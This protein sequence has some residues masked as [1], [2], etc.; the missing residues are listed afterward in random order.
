[1]LDARTVAE[2]R[3]NKPGMEISLTHRYRQPIEKVFAALSTP[4][5][6]AA[7]MGVEWTG[8][9]APLKPGSSFSYRFKNSDMASLGKVTAYEPPRLI[10]HTWFENIP[11]AATV[12]WALAPDRDGCVLT[13]TQS[14]PGK[15]DGARN[16]AGWTMIIGQLDAWL[17][18]APFG[19]RESWAKLRDRY[20]RSMGPEAVRDG[21]RRTRDGQPVVEF[22]RLL[23]HPVAEVW[24]WLTQKARLADWLGDVDVDLRPGGVFRIRFAMAPIVMEGTITKVEAPRRLAMIW[25]EPWFENNDVTLAFALE[26]HTDGT[27]LTLTHTFPANY[28]PQEYLPGWHEFMDAVEDAMEGTPFVWD[29]P[30]RKQAYATRER[31]YK[32]IA[33]AGG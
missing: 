16:G 19:P 12:R 3:A 33:A 6:I 14:Y 21:R 30:E 28:D 13:L 15:D 20:A 24:S 23:R 4:E 10:E 11:P 1:M 22:K 9:A 5:R 18:G 31:V 29:T 7:W 26:P 2:F 8:A 27:L 32:S 17:A 25:R